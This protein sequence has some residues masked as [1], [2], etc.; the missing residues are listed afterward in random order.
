MPSDPILVAESLDKVFRVG[1]ALF[2]RRFNAVSDVSLAVAPGETL[3]IVGESG[4]GKTSL[5]RM[6]VG[7]DRPD[8][9]IIRFHGKPP[10]GKSGGNGATALGP[11]RTRLQ[12]RA[13]QMVFQDP[14]ASLNPR[15]TILDIVAEPLDV[16]GL[17]RGPARRQRVEELLD[18]VGLGPAITSRFP[19]EFSG[20]QR[21]RI[22]IARA[23]A[24]EPA[25]LVCD[26]P[27]SA[28]DVSVQAQ[29]VNLLIDLQRKLG[30]AI[31]FIA[32]DLA[33]VRAMSHRV[34]VMYMGK[35]VETGTV[36]EVLDRP[37]H[38]Y[39]QALRASVLDLDPEIAR[40]RRPLLVLGEPPNP[41]DPPAGCSFH[42][43]CPRATDICRQAV[44]ALREGAG[45][46]AVACV[47]ASTGT[48]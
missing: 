44:P 46:F 14:Y 37:R 34:M 6:L 31:V 5:A 29:V 19:H 9:G 18:L 21:Q 27:V 42:P 45:G 35:V 15:R 17:A 23:L 36:A 43:R 40:S 11:S 33:V 30:L 20:G 26:E 22:G 25:V 47:N 10:A 2:G 7:L 1:G 16:H 48:E 41:V 3:S 12:R 4:S 39:T 32:H 28:L 8:A 13:I 24:A 38:P